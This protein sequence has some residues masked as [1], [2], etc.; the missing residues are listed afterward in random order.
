MLTSMGQITISMCHLILMYD[1]TIITLFTS[2]MPVK[3]T[4]GFRGMHR[5]IF[6]NYG[7]LCEFWRDRAA[8]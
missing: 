1:I 3:D 2:I 5:V 8:E 4:F 6:G 7:E